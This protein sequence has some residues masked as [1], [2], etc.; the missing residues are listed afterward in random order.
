ML[1]TGASKVF[2]LT[3]ILVCRSTLTG[4]KTPVCDIA[5]DKDRLVSSDEEGTI[6]VW[7][8]SKEKLQQVVKIKGS[9]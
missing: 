9:G 5:S 3:I 4:H 6:A 1:L 8:C 2:T 7:K